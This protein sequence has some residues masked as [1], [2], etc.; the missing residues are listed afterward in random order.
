MSKV[1]FGRISFAFSALPLTI[2]CFMPF[3]AHGAEVAPQKSASFR[4]AVLER[5]PCTNITGYAVH[6]A[7]TT[8]TIIF[9]TGLPKLPIFNPPTVGEEIY[10][11]LSP[12]VVTCKGSLDGAPFSLSAQRVLYFS[13]IKGNSASSPTSSPT[14]SSSGSSGAAGG[15][16]SSI[17]S[18]IQSAFSSVFSNSSL[19]STL[20]DQSGAS[21]SS[22]GGGASFSLNKPYGGK[23]LL[24]VPCTCPTD[25]GRKYLITLGPPSP[26]VYLINL[27]TV[28]QRPHLYGMYIVPN[29]NH[30]GF[31]R[32]IPA[33]CLMA[34][35]P[36]FP[37]FAPQGTIVEAGTS[38]PF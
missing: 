7:S 37:V 23:V 21:P 12:V 10:G 16:F 13:R 33:Q 3:F 22:S 28:V 8:E 27:L 15:S 6:I 34:G 11:V 35:T 25:V 1:L 9:Q 2:F 14:P 5:V 26:G 38:L 19:N 17:F 4:G 20:T 32:P 31:V 29:V 24:V 30:L 18:S 36:C